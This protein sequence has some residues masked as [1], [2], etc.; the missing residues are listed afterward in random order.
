MASL[1]GRASKETLTVEGIEV[2]EERTVQQGEPSK[3]LIEVAIKE[4]RPN[5][6]V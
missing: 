5:K 6:T 3:S 2:R 4:G 1:K